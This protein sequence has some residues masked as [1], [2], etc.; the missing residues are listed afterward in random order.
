VDRGPEGGPTR[1]PLASKL[2][3]ALHMG[4]TRGPACLL[5]KWAAN[6]AYLSL[7]SIISPSLEYLRGILTDFPLVLDNRCGGKATFSLPRSHEDGF[8]GLS[9]PSLMVYIGVWERT[10]QT[11]PTS[12][13]SQRGCRSLG[14]K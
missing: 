6:L 4:Q 10:V 9:A 13:T 12:R 7:L 5:F 14:H 2:S 3:V 8:Y 1:A 11:D